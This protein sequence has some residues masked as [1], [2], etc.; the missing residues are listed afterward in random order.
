MKKE[1]IVTKNDFKQYLT[2]KF[3]KLDS[4][5]KIEQFIDMVSLS[6]FRIHDKPKYFGIDKN[7]K[8]IYWQELSEI[9]KNYTRCSFKEVLEIASKKFDWS[10]EEFDFYYDL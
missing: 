3:I 7:G 9:P 8:F 10:K 6:N 5:K 1:E 4:Q 2:L